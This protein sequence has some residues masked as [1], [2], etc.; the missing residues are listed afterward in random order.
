MEQGRLTFHIYH[1]KSRT[2]VAV[3]WNTFEGACRH[4][5]WKSKDCELVR[6]MLSKDVTEEYLREK[7]HEQ[8]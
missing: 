7:R 5:G 2:H 3:L 8:H 6:V 4:S 1:P